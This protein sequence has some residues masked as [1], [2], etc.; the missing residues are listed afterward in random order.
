MSVT[1]SYVVIG[2]AVLQLVV[3]GGYALRDRLV[4]D[5]LLLISALVLVGLLVLMVQCLGGMSRI[6]D[7]TERL[8]FAAYAVSLPF[9]PVGTA[10]LAIKEK[11]RWSMGAV[12]I[13]AFGVAVMTARLLQIWQVAP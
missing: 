10:F 13:G 11:T 12:A 7:E 6:P 5:R 9:V 3:S 2:L 4:D 8:T 1:L